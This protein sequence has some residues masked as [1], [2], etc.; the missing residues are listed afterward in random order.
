MSAIVRLGIRKKLK[1]LE[2]AKPHFFSS[3]DGTKLPL[4]HF[5]FTFK[6]LNGLNQPFVYN[7]PNQANTHTFIPINTLA[8]STHITSRTPTEDTNNHPK[9]AESA[10]S[11][12]I[13]H[14]MPTPRAR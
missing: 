11:I 13:M 5:L 7:K 12:Y 8:K 1:V 4:E 10:T 3:Q 14:S 6:T 2:M 9:H